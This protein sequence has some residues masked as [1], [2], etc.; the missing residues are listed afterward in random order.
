MGVVGISPSFN[1]IQRRW[2]DNSYVFQVGGVLFVVLVSEAFSGLKNASN[3]SV[4]STK[5]IAVNVSFLL[6]QTAEA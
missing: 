2:R 4:S 1:V 6:T 3:W 5:K